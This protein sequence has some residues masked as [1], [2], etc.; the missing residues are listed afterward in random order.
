MRRISVLGLVAL[1]VVGCSG[2]GGG[3][4]PAAK[5]TAIVVTPA[6]PSTIVGGTVAFHATGA[7][8]D[9]TTRDVTAEATWSSST[10]AT[11]TVSNT[12]GTRGVATALAIGTTVVGA[13]LGGIRGETALSVIDATVTAVRIDPAAPVVGVG[14]TV[15]LRCLGATAAGPE[16][17]VT[18]LSTWASDRVDVATVTVGA[19]TGV[20]L[21]TAQLT[22]TFGGFTAQATATV[23]NQPPALVGLEL[24]LPAGATI[25]VGSARRVDARAVYADG[26]RKTVTPFAVFASSAPSVLAFA[27]RSGWYEALAQGSAT[28]TGS[29]SGMT[30]SATVTVGPDGIAALVIDPA[31]QLV[32]AGD[33]LPL[34]ATAVHKSGTT[35]DVTASAVWT[36]DAP[37]VAAVEPTTGVATAMSA[38]SAV[39]R[40]SYAGVSAA[41]ILQVTGSTASQL[42]IDRTTET[43]VVGGTS[44]LSG[45]LSFPDAT[46]AQAD[47]VVQAT[48]ADPAVVAV[49][50]EPDGYLRYRALAA[51]STTVA[52]RAGGLTQTVTVQVLAP[53]ALWLESSLPLV[54]G[55]TTN[56]YATASA[57]TATASVG[58]L[59]S[60]SSDAPSIVEVV[61]GLRGQPRLVAHA[62]GTA[63]LTLSF[64]GV[65]TT[66][67]VTVIPVPASIEVTPSSALLAVTQNQ[68]FTATA[69]LASGEAVPVG[70]A[71]EWVMDDPPVGY[72]GYG[73]FTATRP[74]TSAVIATV[75]G[76]AGRAEVVV[77]ESLYALS[78]EPALA[79]GAVGPYTLPQGTT[80]KFSADGYS[81]HSGWNPDV[82]VAWSSSNQAVATFSTDPAKPGELTAVGPGTTTITATYAVSGG[83]AVTASATVY[84]APLRSLAASPASVSVVPAGTV[85]VAVAGT[86]DDGA[87]GTFTADVTPWVTWTSSATDVARPTSVLTANNAAMTFGIL[88]VSP[89][90]AVLTGTLGGSI[91]DVPVTGL[92]PSVASVTIA[93]HSPDVV[94]LSFA[95]TATAV[96]VPNAAEVDVT[97]LATWSADGVVVG[98]SGSPPIAKVLS[99]GTGT[100]SAAFG[101]ATGTAWVY[102]TAGS[103]T[104]LVPDKRRLTLAPGGWTSIRVEA[105]GQSVSST[106]EGLTVASSNPT[107]ASVQTSGAYVSIA[108]HSPGEALVTASYGGVDTRIA[109]NVFDLPGDFSSLHDSTVLHV[110]ERTSVTVFDWVRNIGVDSQA[111]EAV[112]W[113]S[114]DPTVLKVIGP[115]AIQA[116]KPG[117]AFITASGP[118]W[119]ESTGFTVSSAQLVELYP[120]TPAVPLPVGTAD[121]LRAYARYSDGVRVDVTRDV[122]WWSAAPTAA[123]FDSGTPG[124]VRA[125]AAGTTRVE[126]RLDGLAADAMVTG[127]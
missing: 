41:S 46:S 80:A 45:T 2:G 68:V 90:S 127:F 94:G 23:A 118:A 12:A 52:V 126:C 31:P 72:F 113:T 21:G 70:D 66:A 79:N 5:L 67:T 116:L 50:R 115:G 92:P 39:V 30:A 78:L 122:T 95:P 125:L 27:G 93:T 107:V 43:L 61:Y 123:A 40:A 88:G 74:G 48:V 121:S 51:G 114:S 65:S 36:T 120:S 75:A 103:Y 102:A 13:T 32:P 100:V 112:T 105:R 25:A 73:G 57:G 124:L 44:W 49:E 106:I 47:Q 86:F 87:G 4:Q 76:V 104:A 24:T 109:V 89:G 26:S 63:K 22:A 91:V 20:K 81:Y 69:H 1:A 85:R 3:S 35:E 96:L 29:W 60:W 59:A 108:A 117:H 33:V 9:H 16:V 62:P 19:L 71:V 10:S 54:A 82:A 101:G 7:Y 99:A 58:E 34:R 28:V 53:T 6:N 119:Q 83:T 111:D 97:S 64:G 77:Q 38:G 56:V 98:V 17:D 37:Q 110:H 14:E 42:S 84:V 18:G 55:L 11:A 8:E 15:A